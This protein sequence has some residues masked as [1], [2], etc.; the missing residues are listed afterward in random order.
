MKYTIESDFHNTSVEVAI[1]KE[2][3]N[4][5][6]LDPLEA[7]EYAVYA[8]NSAYAKQKL[9]HIKKVLCGQPDCQCVFNI[10]QE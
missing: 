6:L 8:Y 3:C 9:R 10:I 5:P 2:Y 7:L 1:K 4:A